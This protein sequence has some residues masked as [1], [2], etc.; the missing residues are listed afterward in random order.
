MTI[1]K[2]I[3]KQEAKDKDLKRYFTGVK[4]K[5]GHVSERYTRHGGCVECARLEKRKYQSCPK[6]K[7]RNNIRYR[8]YHADN[9]EKE[10]EYRKANIQKIRVYRR[11]RKEKNK[12]Q[13]PNWF[14]EFDSFVLSE[15]SELCIIREKETGIQWHIDH[16]FPLRAKLVCGLHCAEN[17]QVIPAKFNTSK[18]NKLIFTN[19]Y[20]W[21]K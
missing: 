21:L 16:M 18:Q 8:K 4:C 12:E 11:N 19:R 1:L 13:T 15:S 5:H 6:V 2:I 9:K 20:E 7:E 14:G 3:S 17:F 10:R